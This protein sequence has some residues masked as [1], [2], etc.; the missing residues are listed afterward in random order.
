MS[1]PNPT[2]ISWY[3]G[4]NILVST[5]S[6]S[7]LRY[8]MSN[9]SRHD[10]G[11]YTCSSQ[12]EIGNASS[13]ISLVISYPPGV[14]IRPSNLN[15]HNKNREI[16]CIAQGEPDSY[17]YF[18]WEHR[19]QF[20][21]HIRY[22][23][24]TDSGILHLPEVN[25]SNRYQDTG[26][27]ICNVS[28]GIPNYHGNVFQQGRKYIVSEVNF[29]SEAKVLSPEGIIITIIVFQI[30][31][32]VL[33]AGMGLYVRYLKQ[34]YRKRMIAAINIQTLE[35]NGIESAHYAEITEDNFIQTQ[36]QG[37]NTHV[38]STA[39]GIRI[40]VENRGISHLSEE[41]S[42]TISENDIN[43][44]EILDDGY[45]KPY[46]TLVVNDRDEDKHIYL[47]TTNNSTNENSTPSEN[48]ACGH[49]PGFTELDSSPHRTNTPIYENDCQEN[50]KLHYFENCSYQ[51]DF[52]RPYVYKHR[53]QV[54]YI[55]LSL[56]QQSKDSN[57]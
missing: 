3:K 41:R 33:V 34:M 53:N 6:K 56:K 31:I 1:N 55:N 22:L 23:G 37:N 17:N 43:A 45:E 49:S 36:S 35:R 24:A 27:Y 20:D 18:P 54:E 40:L 7:S 9:V 51:R 47:S 13:D 14:N 30:I 28:N 8:K 10:T 42:S 48:A 52:Q 32:V 50:V 11:N 25:L 12:N 39:D 29:S 46:S 57:V 19:S 26:F 38:F 5:N 2:S 15:E 4:D 44:S 21:E 16:Q